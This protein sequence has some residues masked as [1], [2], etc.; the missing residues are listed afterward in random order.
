MKGQ[1]VLDSSGSEEGQVRA[2]L[3]LV[4]KLHIP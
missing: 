4:M 1:H 2:A 3:N